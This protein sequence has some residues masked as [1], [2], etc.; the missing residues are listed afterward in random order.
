MISFEKNTDGEKIH[1][2]NFNL[3]V[4]AAL[5]AAVLS[6]HC[7]RNW[8]YGLH[9]LPWRKRPLCC[10]C[11]SVDIFISS[12]ILNMVNYG[13][14]HSHTQVKK[15]RRRHP[16][17]TSEEKT[18]LVQHILVGGFIIISFDIY[19]VIPKQATRNRCSA[20]TALRA[21][22]SQRESQRGQREGQRESQRES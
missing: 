10:W 8:R 5:G 12:C 19:V 6:F 21:R 20:V 1:I 15:R 18:F 9:K 13:H 7:I 4:S 3:S 2:L 11:R 22:E 17:L 14:N 16:V